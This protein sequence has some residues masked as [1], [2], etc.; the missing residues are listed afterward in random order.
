MATLHITCLVLFVFGLN[1]MCNAFLVQY[2]LHVVLAG[3][4]I[5]VVSEWLA[6]APASIL[7][8]FSGL[9]L[10]SI[11]FA[12]YFGGSAMIYLFFYGVY[13]YVLENNKRYIENF[14]CIMVQSS[15]FIF[16][17]YFVA[18]QMTGGRIYSLGTTIILSQILI[19]FFE[20]FLFRITTLTLPKVDK[21]PFNIAQNFSKNSAP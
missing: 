9:S 17:I 12:P 2:D 8:I 18:T 10:D 20:K 15:N 16:I 14:P 7:L 5:R 3:V 19:Y 6:I 13:R 1:A 11:N 21:N 4:I